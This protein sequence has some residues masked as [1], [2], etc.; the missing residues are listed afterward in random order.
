MNY[1]RDIICVQDAHIIWVPNVLPSSDFHNVFLL[2]VSDW[3]SKNIYACVH[4]MRSKTACFS[5]VMHYTGLH[6]KVM[7]HQLLLTQYIYLFAYLP[8]PLLTY[9]N[10]VFEYTFDILV[11]ELLFP[12]HCRHL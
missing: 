8:I 9:S 3:D 12:F 6:L 2:W 11:L 1:I 7:S 4:Q 5:D 10:I